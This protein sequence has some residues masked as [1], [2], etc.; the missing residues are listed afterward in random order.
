MIIL[1]YFSLKD[2]M[3]WK[4]IYFQNK[5]LSNVKYQDSS[6]YDMISINPI[7]FVKKANK[8]FTKYN[9]KVSNDYSKDFT[10]KMKGMG[11]ERVYNFPTE[12]FL[13]CVKN[14][15]C[16]EEDYEIDT[17][18]VLRK[19]LIRPRSRR[20][21]MHA[22]SMSVIML[23]YLK[24]GFKVEIVTENTHKTPDLKI[25]NLNCE[26]KTLMEWDWTEEM[27][28]L[29]GKGKEKSH[30]ENLCYDIGIFISKKNSGHKGI[31]QSDVIFADLSLKSLGEL[32]NLPSDLQFDDSSLEEFL[33]LVEDSRLEL[34]ELKE[35]RIIFFSRIKTECFGFYIDFQPE[36]WSFIKKLERKST[37]AIY[38]PPSKVL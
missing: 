3:G 33:K 2:D 26:I 6:L 24:K 9:I 23:Y 28:L 19:E 30:S 38:P 10:I 20:R 4:N 17:S 37:K 5:L 15:L 32:F 18:K 14:C 35:N 13:L 12:E 16:I 22:C 27:N 25:N 8:L 11:W 1:E 21:V 36:L 29:T 34:P 7:E 31:K